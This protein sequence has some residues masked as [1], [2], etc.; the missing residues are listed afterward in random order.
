M[1]YIQHSVGPGASKTLML[2]ILQTNCGRGRAATIEVGVKLRSYRYTVAIIMEPYVDKF[3]RITGLPNGTRIY[4]N[5]TKKAAIFVDDPNAVILPIDSMT[6]E[7][8]VCISI[9][10][11]YGSF[12]IVSIYCQFNAP[13]EPYIQYLDAVTSLA[14]NKRLIAGL[15]AN[16]TSPM[17]HSKMTNNIYANQ[18]SRERG[19]IL[20]EWIIHR[21]SL[22]LNEPSEVYTFDN[23]RAHS[24]ID[25][26]LINEAA[27]RRDNY[28][29]KITPWNLSD[30][31]IIT[32]VISSEDAVESLAPV[33]M[34]K[35][36]SGRWSRFKEEIQNALQD[37]DLSL[38]TE[39]AACELQTLVQQT[40][41]IVFGK[42]TFKK[43]TKIKWWTRELGSEKRKVIRLRR[44]LQ[45]ARSR[46]D[47]NA[48]ALAIELRITVKGYK[49]MIQ[50]A[51]EENWRQF[52]SQ[53]NEDPWGVV[54]K[55]CRGK[56]KK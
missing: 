46:G 8:G 7:Y 19:E 47:P 20:S 44:K 39:D 25:V 14:R 43:Q 33:P 54:Y 4:H 27:S 9:T 2:N 26:T 28:T 32:V 16:A 3:G 50:T 52:V 45:R 49:K 15:D 23:N 35:L 13:L 30:H 41:D 55:I 56:K 12:F 5:A 17:W 36:H 24:D 1:P 31:N 34:W 40:C 51:K 11:T 21:N 38:P 29:W 22:V 6:N 37:S 48:I 10:S 42:K 18:L 53:H